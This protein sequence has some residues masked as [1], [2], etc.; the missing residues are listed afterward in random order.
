MGQHVANALPLIGTDAACIVVEEQTLEAAMTERSDHPSVY[1][2]S[3]QGS[4]QIAI[5]SPIPRENRA[6]SH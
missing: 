2:V 4:K 6:P 5:N 3:V 1:R